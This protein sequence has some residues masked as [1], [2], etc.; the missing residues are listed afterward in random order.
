MDTILSLNLIKTLFAADSY[1]TCRLP[2]DSKTGHPRMHPPG[3]ATRL[4]QQNG[5][6]PPKKYLRQTVAPMPDHIVPLH[7]GY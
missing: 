7:L 6:H 3:I 1:I 5:T 4:Q 2:P